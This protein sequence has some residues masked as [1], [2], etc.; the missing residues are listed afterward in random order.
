MLATARTGTCGAVVALGMLGGGLVPPLL[1]GA[2][3][4]GSGSGP[5][6]AQFQT[7]GHT[8]EANGRLRRGCHRYRYTYEVAPPSDE[9]SLETFLLGPRGKRLASDVIISGADPAD[10][11][12]RWQICRTNTRAGRFTIRAR[13]NYNDYPDTYS[14][15]LKSSHFRLRR[16]R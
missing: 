11:S 1:P 16:H 13:L 14:G 10:G 15:W 5:T 12:K 6:A 2:D 9:W 4:G 8:H 3:G 7:M